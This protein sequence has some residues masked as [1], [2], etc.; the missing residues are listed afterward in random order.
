M[1]Q[2][3]SVIWV[4][5]PSSELNA[6][7]SE[8]LGLLSTR[9]NLPLLRMTPR[10]VKRLLDLAITIPTLILL[11]I[12]MGMI[13]IAIKIRLAGTGHLMALFVWVNTAKN[14]RAGSFERWFP[15]AEQVL[16]ERLESDP[17]ARCGM[18]ARRRS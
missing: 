3:P 9:T 16:E 13:A 7:A 2:F 6:E 5:Q 1:F 18:G 17:E 4:E 12:P 14:S 11:A 15:N 8:L 10:V